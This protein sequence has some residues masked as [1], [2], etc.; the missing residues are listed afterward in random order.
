MPDLCLYFQVHQPNRL[1]PSVSASGKSVFPYEDDE[2]NASIL[3]GVADRCYL[4]ANRLFKRLIAKHEGRFR[5][6]M[7][8]SGTAIDQMQRHRPDVLKSFQELVAGG[9]V[10]LLAETYYHSLAF[11]HSGREFERQ[12]DLHLEKMEELFHVRPKGLLQH[13]VDL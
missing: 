12:V 9:G 7:S 10:E 4:P 11:V 2:M 1:L 3:S 13:R 5:I 8:I 6:A